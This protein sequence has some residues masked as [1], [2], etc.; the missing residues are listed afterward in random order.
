MFVVWL[1]GV[2]EEEESRIGRVDKD[3]VNWDGRMLIMC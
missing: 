1:F 2:L 3:S